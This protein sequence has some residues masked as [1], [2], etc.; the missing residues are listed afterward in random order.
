MIQPR[1]FFLYRH[2]M[3]ATCTYADNYVET[4]DEDMDL[5]INGEYLMYTRG[6]GEVGHVC[7]G[8][9]VNNDNQWQGFRRPG[10]KNRCALPPSNHRQTISSFAARHMAAG[11][12]FHPASQFSPLL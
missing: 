8:E 6:Q 4:I 2:L 3:P 12:F 5:E 7:G 1:C 11:V 9:E 10:Q